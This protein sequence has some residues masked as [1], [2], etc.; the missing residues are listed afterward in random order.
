[1]KFKVTT[2]LVLFF[3]LTISANAQQLVRSVVASAGNEYVGTAFSL[4]SNV[5]EPVS[6]T[7]SSS[8][9][10]LTQGFVQSYQFTP[11]SSNQLSNGTVSVQLYP[12]PAS[13]YFTLNE[14]TAKVE[15]YSITGQ[16]V[17]SF[18]ANKTAGSQFSISDLN[19]GLYIVK[20]FDENNEMKVLKLLKN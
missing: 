3:V 18:D 11:L 2:L 20:T 10:F 1:M 15:I 5:G 7:F 4:W 19:Q 9:N 16:L 12:N 6:E 14:T 8:S 13:D 17:K